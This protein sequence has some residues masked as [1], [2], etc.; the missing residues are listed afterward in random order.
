MEYYYSKNG[1]DKNGPFRFDEIKQKNITPKT[2]IWYEELEDWKMAGQLPILKNLIEGF[3]VETLDLSKEIQIILSNDS[4]S[5][6]I[7]SKEEIEILLEKFFDSNEINIHQNEWINYIPI[8]KLLMGFSISGGCF[9]FSNDKFCV[10]SGIKKRTKVFDIRDFDKV[11]VVRG[12]LFSD[13][14]ELDGTVIGKFNRGNIDHWNRI[15]NEINS[16]FKSY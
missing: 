9:I 13:N 5:D 14:I 1:I 7:K 6:E 3:V 11:K 8:N 2:L 12:G 15:Y 10:S 16:V 4:L